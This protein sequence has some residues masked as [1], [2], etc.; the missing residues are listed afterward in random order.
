[1][2]TTSHEPSLELTV[3]VL[4]VIVTTV[5]VIIIVIVII[6]VTTS[7]VLIC[8]ISVEVVINPG[9][10]VVAEITTPD[11]FAVEVITTT[12]SAAAVAVLLSLRFTGA[13][14]RMLYGV[15]PWNRVSS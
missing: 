9:F 7:D 5:L 2:F 4:L 6:V 3:T 15:K 14:R 10:L 11:I 12:S 13:L 1:M 8:P